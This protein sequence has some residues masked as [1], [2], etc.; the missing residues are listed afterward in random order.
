MFGLYFK[1]M[2]SSEYFETV[3]LGFS[4]DLGNENYLSED[5][6]L[7]GT[8]NQRNESG[9]QILDSVADGPAAV[10]AS[11]RSLIA[12]DH[13]LFDRDY[14]TVDLK[15]EAAWTHRLPPS[16]WYRP[17]ELSVRPMDGSLSE[18]SAHPISGAAHS[19]LLRLSETSF[20][21]NGET[22]A[23]EDRPNARNISNTVMSQSG[24]MPNAAGASDF[25]WGWGQFIDHDIGITEAGSE[26][27]DIAIA[28]GE[29][30][31][32]P[33][34]T[35]TATIAFNRVDDADPDTDGRQYENEIT[36]FIDGSQ[37]YG[38]SDAEADILR[39]D[40]GKLIMTSDGY[41][42]EQDGSFMTGDV[43]AAENIVLTSMHTLFAR[44]HNRLADVIAEQRPYLDDDALF[45]EVRARVEAQ[46]QAITFNEFLPM[47]VGEGAF[48]TYDGY[49]AAVDPGLSVEFTTAIFRF[50]HTMLSS[51]LL[52]TE[53]NGDEIEGRHIA[54]RDAFFALDEITDNGGVDPIL[55]GA[56]EGTAQEIDV[57][58]VDDVRSFLFG[59]PG[60]GGFDLAALNIQRGRDLGIP[61]YN[62]LREAL[63]LEA[64]TSFEEISSDTAVVEA[65]RTAYND[66]IT[67]IDAWVGGLAEDAFGDGMLGETF[68]VGLVDQFTR[69][70]DGDPFWSEGR[71]FSQRELDDL[72]E[73]RLSDII[74]RNT[75]IDH[76]QRDAFIAHDRI[77]GTN[78][79]DHL[80]GSAADDLM[81]G[82]RGR[83]VLRGMDG[84][85]D[86]F[87]DRGRDTLIG[88]AGDD[89]LTGGAGRDTFVFDAGIAGADV[90]TD[91]ES[92]DRLVIDNFDR[93]DLHF[94]YGNDGVVAWISDVASITFED[95]SSFELALQDLLF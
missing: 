58:I 56:A 83:D 95:P 92:G 30:L 48:D 59:P 67:L 21:D 50:G 43:R 69:L 46:M 1:D 12:R 29:P 52:R 80:T 55:R 9:H 63:G 70:R 25:L 86:L 66:D 49:D 42:V 15:T 64:V 22:L 94:D 37:I 93:H 81:I 51:L 44:E 77:G 72:W 26:P 31:F 41:L 40:G 8:F 33:Y 28:L 27:A 74:E 78:G 76:I 39:I 6:Y 16:D 84:D 88:G 14:A 35:G 71:G 91:F 45:N 7:T 90:I 18:G 68:S 36:A 3:Y 2:S 61:T 54:L 20:E 75:D 17:V 13:P 57:N 53:E 23:G 87:G 73:T 47:L 24:D 60:A 89:I 11:S 65:L 38:S 85:D 34:Y 32:D 4:R 10:G 82:F 79:R 62:G 5:A 19:Y